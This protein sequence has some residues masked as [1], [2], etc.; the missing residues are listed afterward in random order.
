[1][2]VL[3][4]PSTGPVPWLYSQ[5]WQAQGALGTLKVYRGTYCPC[6]TPAPGTQPDPGQGDPTCPLCQGLGLMYPNNA[7]DIQCLLTDAANDKSLLQAGLAEPGQMQAATPPGG[8]HLG[9]WDLCLLPWPP[10]IPDQGQLIVRGN[11]STDETWYRLEAMGGIWSEPN[12]ELHTY[13]QGID[14]SWSGRTITWLSSG[15]APSAGQTYSV[16]YAAR[17]EWIVAY[18]PQVVVLWGQDLGMRGILKK[19]HEVFPSAGPIM[20]G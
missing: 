7:I 4:P 20:R 8:P 5:M 9:L 17:Y 1:M 12:G 19:R 16:R 15:T 3:P 13:Q 6:A 10:G 11:G 18:A 2:S 14:Y